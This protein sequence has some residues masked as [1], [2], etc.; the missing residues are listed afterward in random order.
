MLTGIVSSQCN[1]YCPIPSFLMRDT[2][3]CI[4]LLLDV[5]PRTT[6]DLSLYM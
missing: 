5:R 1:D 6:K 2:I 3:I 4:E